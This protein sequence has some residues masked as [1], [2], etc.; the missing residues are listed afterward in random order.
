[1]LMYSVKYIKVSH[2]QKSGI[3]IPYAEPINFSATVCL[4]SLQ[5]VDFPIYIIMTCW[6]LWGPVTA[7]YFFLLNTMFLFFSCHSFDNNQK[8][9]GVLAT[10]FF[11]P[12]TIIRPECLL[13]KWKCKRKRRRAVSI[14]RQCFI[15][16]SKDCNSQET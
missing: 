12:I 14:K 15:Y 5:G 1:M 6:F 11:M 2:M 4:A 13:L 9:C 7:L 8:K 3:D 16:L 10:L